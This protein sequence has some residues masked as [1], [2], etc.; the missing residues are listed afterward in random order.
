MD[1]LT[2]EPSKWWIGFVMTVAIIVLG[3]ISFILFVCSYKQWR[4]KVGHSLFV[5]TITRHKLYTIVALYTLHKLTENALKH[6]PNG[7]Q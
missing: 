4:R 2:D 1:N 6:P 5:T 7:A 3:V